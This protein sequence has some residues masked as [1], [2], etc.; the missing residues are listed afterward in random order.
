[1]KTKTILT[2]F[3]LLSILLSILFSCQTDDINSELESQNTDL[4]FAIDDSGKILENIP[5]EILTLV[6]TSFPR[7][8]MAIVRSG[9]RVAKLIAAKKPAAPPPIIR[10][11]LF[12]FQR[13]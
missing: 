3:T 9:L 7:S 12:I 2:K 11:S 1:M 4:K 10:T 5:P 13:F 6:S 8:K